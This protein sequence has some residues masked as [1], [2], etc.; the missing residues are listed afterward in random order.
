MNTKDSP[1][2]TSFPVERGGVGLPGERRLDRHPDVSP[3]IRRENRFQIPPRRG[4]IKRPIALT[5]STLL[6]ACSAPVA[7]PQEAA[8]FADAPRSGGR[9]PE[10]A[11]IPAGRFRTR[12]ASA[13]DCCDRV[14]SVTEAEV[15]PA[16]AKYEATH[17][18]RD[19]CNHPNGVHDRGSGRAPRPVINVSWNG[20][21]AYAARRGS[22]TVCVWDD[23]TGRNPAPCSDSRSAPAC[24]DR[25]APLA[26][27][28]SLPAE[29][30]AS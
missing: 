27:A 29:L 8:A 20:A 23:G 30:I 26:P 22:A 19:R 15:S 11:A 18:N 4:Q 2:P 7:A 21:Q 28:G 12:R 24:K 6:P 10:T 1:L 13:P 5:G 3:P 16:F 9:A 14:V 17:G 25:W